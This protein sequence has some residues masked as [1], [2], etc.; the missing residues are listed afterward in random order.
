MKR[1][2][3]CF[4]MGM[5][6]SVGL[7]CAAW[8]AAVPSPLSP[9][10]QEVPPPNALVT[11][12][13]ASTNPGLA[14]LPATSVVVL[15]ES[16][17]DRAP[18]A[19]TTTVVVVAT[20]P[21]PVRAANTDT[22]YIERGET[23]AGVRMSTNA[24][25]MSIQLDQ[26]PLE[27]VVKLFVRVSGANIIVSGTNLAGQVVT[28]NLDN[29]E[30]KPA[31]I[32]ILNQFNLDLFEKAAGSQIY[33]IGP[34]QAG[35]T[36]PMISENFPLSFA[37][38]SNVL[39]VVTSILGAGGGSVVSFPAGNS[40]VVRGTDRQLQEVRTVIKAID[41][42]RKQVYIETKFIELTD[43]AIKDLGINWQSLQNYT[44]TA[45]PFTRNITDTRNRIQGQIN[46][47]TKSDIR[48]NTD[49]TAQ[50][51]DQNGVQIPGNARTVSDN[52]NRGRTVNSTVSDT[53]NNT[54]NDART[55]VLSA[56][57]FSLVLS[58][59]QQQNG[60]SIV[61]NPKLIVANEASA[62]IHIGVNQPNVRGSVVP[63]QQG[64]ANTTTYAL[65][66]TQPYFKFGI[67]LDVTPTINTDSNITVRIKPTLS[68]RVLPDFTAPD[69]TSYPQT[70]ETTLDTV[71]SLGAERTAVIGGLTTTDTEDHVVKIPL[72]GDI[73]ILG[74]YLFSH[75]SKSKKQTE[76]IIFVTVGI[77]DPA[78]MLPSIGLPREAELIME[79]LKS[80]GI[81]TNRAPLL[82]DVPPEAAK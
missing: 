62:N 8:S 80:R 53:I 14:T 51:F 35:M 33:S 46:T 24:N 19:S 73:P 68:R 22:L 50:N 70:S 2:A 78:V 36:E 6:A 17:A 55:A 77:A 11:L 56:P 75:Q 41:N 4:W 39:P 10:P 44:V 25:L 52:I 9:L 20:E 67:T 49:N 34:K 5:T 28:A 18:S 66:G 65:D 23:S 32:S 1:F 64:Q 71:F 45:G 12:T 40:L 57:A 7:A 27:E 60:I 72:L 37:T 63:G 79:H 21:A 29:V 82:N 26:T 54:F 58:A 31:L 69:G 15:A 59:L 38:V 16:A 42:P 13:E 81:S 74:K 48:N 76:T 30:W 47:D 61:S 43:E 3:K